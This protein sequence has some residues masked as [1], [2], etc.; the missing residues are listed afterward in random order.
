MSNHDQPMS[1]AQLVKLA[2]SPAGLKLMRQIQNTDP[3][4]MQQAA[5]FFA[6]GDIASAKAAIGTLL[7]DP[8]IKKLLEELGR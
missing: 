6:A 7:E 3:A 5:Q 8:Q 4:Q 1:M 2:S